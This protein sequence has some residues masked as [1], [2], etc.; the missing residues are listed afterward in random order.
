MTDTAASLRVTRW[1]IHR[2]LDTGDLSPVR[3]GRVR[4]VHVPSV[5][6]FLARTTV[7]A[8]QQELSRMSRTELPKLSTLQEVVERF[9]HLSLRVLTEDAR[10]GK[11]RHY[12]YGRRRFMDDEQIQA[13][14][15]SKEVL[16]PEEAALAKVRARRS[17]RAA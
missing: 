7:P 6:D 3:V 17:R 10:R 13:L 9:P 8:D 16:P 5:A 1:T 12:H 2:L 14:L 4:H 15:A 11:F